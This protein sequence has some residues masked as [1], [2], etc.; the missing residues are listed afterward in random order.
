MSESIFQKNKGYKFSESTNTACFV[1][2]HVL[3]ENAPILYVTHD[4]DDGV[5]Q[6]LCGGENHETQHARIVAL[7]EIAKIDLSI[8]ELYDMPLGVGASRE[9]ING[10]WKPFKKLALPQNLWVNSRQ[11]T[12]LGG[13]AVSPPNPLTPPGRVRVSPWT[14][15]LGRYFKVSSAPVGWGLRLLREPVGRAEQPQLGWQ[16]TTRCL[17]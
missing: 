6:F 7:G 16:R 3:E 17:S 11:A 4:E 15:Q 10:Q 12:H 9:S 13:F 8:N 5:W 1:C 14:G 2:S